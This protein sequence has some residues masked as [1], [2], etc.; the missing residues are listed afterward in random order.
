MLSMC[1]LVGMACECDKEIEGLAFARGEDENFV[2][3]ELCMAE[4]AG[5][6]IHYLV[7]T[8]LVAS[9]SGDSNKIK[10]AERCLTAEHRG[11]NMKMVLEQT[12]TR[13]LPIE[14]RD[15]REKMIFEE[16]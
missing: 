15:I 16:L 14:A 6:R 11:E 9:C 1:D 10:E 5:R 2:L 4:R 12:R 3:W 13:S 8:L 7:E